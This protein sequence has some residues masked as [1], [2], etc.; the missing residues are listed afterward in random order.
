MRDKQLTIAQAKEACRTINMSLTK[1]Q[2]GDYRVN[3][4]PGVEA[5]AYYTDC[6]E[7]A[8]DTAFAMRSAPAF[9]QPMTQ[10][11]DS[12]DNKFYRSSDWARRQEAR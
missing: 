4:A 8:L 11:L 7:D 1:T 3:Y 6:L 5:T 9:R 10:E 12:T 2:A